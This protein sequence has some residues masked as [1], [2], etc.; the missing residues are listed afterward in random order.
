METITK[1]KTTE[2]KYDVYVSFD[3][4][5]FSNPDECKKYEDSA[6]GVLN[7]KY[8]K[9]LIGRTDECSLMGIGSDESSVEILKINTQKD[10]DLVM[11]MYFLINPH[12][13]NGNEKGEKPYVEWVNRATTLLRKAREE[14]DYLFVG[15][16]YDEEEYFWFIGTRA[17]VLEKINDVINNASK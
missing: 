4:K 6:L 11:Q 13:K 10:E 5:E 2:T 15:R 17:G 3:G 12:I 16:G 7:L 14:D 1:V 8:K 9:L